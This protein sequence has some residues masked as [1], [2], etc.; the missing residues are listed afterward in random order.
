MFYFISSV[1]ESEDQ[2]FG[3]L[4]ASQNEIK[5]GTLNNKIFVNI[6]KPNYFVKKDNAGWDPNTQKF[7]LKG[8][9]PWYTKI[10]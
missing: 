6:S 8:M 10:V 4:N 1:K 9:I 3:H 5:A 2:K 7:K